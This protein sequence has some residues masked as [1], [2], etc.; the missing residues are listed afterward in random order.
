[1]PLMGMEICSVQFMCL[2]RAVT[3]LVMGGCTREQM[4]RVYSAGGY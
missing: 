3:M 2:T 4:A 1:M